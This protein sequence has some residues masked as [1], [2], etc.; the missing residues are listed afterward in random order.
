ME[1]KI[2]LEQVPMV[3]PLLIWLATGLFKF[4]LSCI[5]T[6]KITLQHIGSGGFPSNHTAIIAGTTM[7]IGFIYGFADPVFVLGVAI[8]AII[9]FD[10]LGLRK[11]VGKHSTYLNK[12]KGDSEFRERTGHSSREVLG[13]AIWGV[14][15][16]YFLSQL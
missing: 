16:A 13:G 15:I 11:E 9:I 14:L 7:F 6:R 5:R 3:A 1:P 2:T 10:A 12:L 8:T 4:A